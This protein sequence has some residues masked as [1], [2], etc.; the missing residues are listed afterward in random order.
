MEPKSSLPHSQVPATCPYPEPSTPTPRFV[1]I[2]LNIIP[3]LL[4][5]ISSFLFPSGFPTKTLRAHH[6]HPIRA[7]CP[8]HLI[9]PDVITRTDH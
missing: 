2:N 9:R 3:H 5:G 1:N 6:L 7:T 4:F 8:A